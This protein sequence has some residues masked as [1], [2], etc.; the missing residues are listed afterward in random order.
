MVTHLSPVNCL[1]QQVHHIFSFTASGLETFGPLEENPLWWKYPTVNGSGCWPGGTAAHAHQLSVG[2]A[3][4]V[5]VRA[6]RR[7]GA[8]A[9]V[10]PELRGL[11]VL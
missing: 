2:T 9:E 5:A 8:S 3:W 10:P 7:E 6:S 11:H 4:H 1:L